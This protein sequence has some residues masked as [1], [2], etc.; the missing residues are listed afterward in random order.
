MQPLRA[1]FRVIRRSAT[2]YFQ[3]RWE[4]IAP[5]VAHGKRAVALRKL[6]D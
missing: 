6:V 3:G 1:G 5:P 4:G 2:E